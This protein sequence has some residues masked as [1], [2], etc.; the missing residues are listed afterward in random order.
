MASF[1]L[2][3]LLFLHLAAAEL[4]NFDLPKNQ[5]NLKQKPNKESIPIHNDIRIKDVQ[6]INDMEMS[7]SVDLL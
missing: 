6:T 7:F 1:L 4:C 5:G 2:C 3:L